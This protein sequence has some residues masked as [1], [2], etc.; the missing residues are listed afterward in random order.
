MGPLAVVWGVQDT[1]NHHDS[2][3]HNDDTVHGYT[4]EIQ[5]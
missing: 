3:S 5:R 2:N 4:C 1:Q